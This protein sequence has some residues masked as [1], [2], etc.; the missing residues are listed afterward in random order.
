[1]SE[2]DKYTSNFKLIIFDLDGAL[3]ASFPLLWETYYQTMNEHNYHLTREEVIV[4]F[5]YLQY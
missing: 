1:M 3:I 4:L 2:D 5:F